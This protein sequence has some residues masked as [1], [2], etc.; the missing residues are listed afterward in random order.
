MTHRE[1]KKKTGIDIRHPEILKFIGKCVSSGMGWNGV[2]RAIEKDYATK[3]TSVYVKKVYETY[4]QRRSE[5]IEGDQDLRDGIKDEILNWKDQVQ[6]INQVTWQIINDMDTKQENKIK[7][8]GEVRKQ[9][10]LQ[11]KILDRMENN[12][13]K[14]EMNQLEM[15][16][17]LFT[18]LKKLEEDGMI[19]ILQLP[20]QGMSLAKVIEDA[21]VIDV[22]ENKEEEEDGRSRKDNSEQEDK[23]G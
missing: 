14:Q 15:T 12:F 2:A 4:V 18:Q 13:S 9:L 20:G 16:K 3:T 17:F 6:K 11:S 8:M 1:I 21:P 22:S 23:Y 5:I 10:D 7:A 19:K